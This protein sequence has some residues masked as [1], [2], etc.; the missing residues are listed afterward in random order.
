[1]NTR[2]E[3]IVSL[4]KTRGT[5]MKGKEL[6]AALD[7][8]TRTIRSDIDAINRQLEQG[9]I[10][11]SFQQGY[12]LSAGYV[13]VEKKSA[14][15]IPQTAEERQN[16]ILKQIFLSKDV[17]LT[18]LP[19]MVCASQYTVESDLKVIRK[20]LEK[21]TDLHLVQKQNYLSLQ[22]DE[23]EKRQL[24]KRLLSAEVEENFM[25][26]DSLNSLFSEFDLITVRDVL[27]NCLQ[28][29]DFNMRPT[30]MPMILLH[31][32]IALQ[33][34]LH[35]NPVEDDPGLRDLSQTT[36]YA[37]AEQF[38]NKMAS[39]Y[40]INVPTAEIKQLALMLMGRR[41][42]AFT[43]DQISYQ[44]E[45]VVISKLVT[46]MIDAVIAGCGIDFSDDKPLHQ[47]LSLHLR[48]LIQRLNYGTRIENVYQSELRRKFPFIYEMGVYAA[49]A[50]MNEIDA[51]L[52]ADEIG[53]LALHFGSAFNRLN[54]NQ[55]YRA[56]FLFPSDQA[57][58][59]MVVD[60]IN[61]QFSE[62]MEIVARLDVFED[63][64]VRRL[65]PDLI[66]STV[67]LNHNFRIPTVDISVFYTQENENAIFQTLNALDKERSRRMFERQIQNLILPEF[68][69]NALEARTPE[70][71][72]DAMCKPLEENGFVGESFKQ[73]V[74]VREKF[75][76]TSFQAGFALPHSF[77]VSA[78]R[79]AISIAYLKDPIDWGGNQVDF[80]ILLAIREEE[81]NI[82]R[83]FFDWWTQVIADPI[84]Y[85]ELKMQRTHA[86]FME[87]VLNG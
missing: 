11:S 47:G 7:V 63:T 9:K 74:F 1:M 41:A 5:W 71:V 26:M 10:E 35:F 83:I 82:L 29:N 15:L 85:Q 38:W 13:G 84:H 76:S 67:P 3:K 33:R 59:K 77:A 73:S 42:T 53:F 4:L 60:K 64:L 27:E 31:I 54:Q 69:H 18:L 57:L 34:L 80:V 50:L 37:A 20:M 68:F 14:D 25:N 43:D 19:E 46:S 40:L 81:K 6:A 52:T 48:A 12:R 22:G 56:L 17:N 58:G 75:A 55:K 49:R 66:L 79:S 65:Y 8:S 24:Y 78:K 61:S 45:V 44:G 70:D 30:A 21:D 28:D 2:Q 39:Y 51:D 16:F 32:G 36:E 23:S 86:A 62:R 72:V 87:A